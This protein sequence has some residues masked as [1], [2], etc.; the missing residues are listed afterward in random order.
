MLAVDGYDLIGYLRTHDAR[1][2]PW[3][4]VT[5][6]DPYGAAARGKRVSPLWRR[7]RGILRASGIASALEKLCRA[8]GIDRGRAHIFRR[9]AAI[10][11][12]EAAMAHPQ[13]VQRVLRMT[14]D[15]R[16]RYLVSAAR[17]LRHAIP[18]DTPAGDL[19]T[20][21]ATTTA[22]AV[23]TAAT[24]AAVLAAN[25]APSARSRS[26]DGSS[27]STGGLMGTRTKGI[28]M[29]NG[30]GMTMSHNIND[31]VKNINDEMNDEMMGRAVTDDRRIATVR[32]RK[33]PRMRPRT[34]PPTLADVFRVA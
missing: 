6:D 7:T 4:E 3:V 23:S 10:R 14:E 11:M 26:S 16:R 22:A 28:E 19:L 17:S 24:T 12:N 33:A 13:A 31:K 20:A 25:A 34:P 21:A 9:W 32:T 18:D 8:A 1:L 29:T 27:S 15:T 5:R 2:V 30:I